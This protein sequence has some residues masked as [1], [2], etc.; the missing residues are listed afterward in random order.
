MNNL[1]LLPKILVGAAVQSQELNLSNK[2]VYRV[3]ARLRR[4]SENVDAMDQPEDT[5][6]KQKT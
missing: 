6:T 3:S 1:K 5:L 2:E 4:G